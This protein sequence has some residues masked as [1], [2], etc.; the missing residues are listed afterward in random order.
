ML[1]H[2]F[3]KLFQKHDINVFTSS[4]SA[5]GL[6]RQLLFATSDSQNI[7]LTSTDSKSSDLYYSFK[8]QCYGGASIIFHCH[9]KG[10]MR[11]SHVRV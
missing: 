5:P 9:H 4:I 1:D 10:G 2:S 6:S 11:T 8:K 3:Q 7:L